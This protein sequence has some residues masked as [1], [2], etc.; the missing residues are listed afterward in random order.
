MASAYT[1]V[2]KFQMDGVKIDL[3]FA[4]VGN[5]QWLRDHSL[6]KSGRGGVND[7]AGDSTATINKGYDGEELQEI[8]DMELDDTV[9]VGLDETSVRSV[10]G[11][12][13]AQ[14]LMSTAGTSA[15]RLENFRLTLRAVKEWA[16]RIA[17]SFALVQTLLQLNIKNVFRFLLLL[18]QR[19]HGLYSNVLGFLGGVNWAILVCWVFKV[20]VSF[21]TKLADVQ[22][23]FA[24]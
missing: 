10:N 24:H 4:R 12:R 14:F 5:S 18:S 3:I 20:G 11:V 22:S 9:L 17:I 15:E 23:I 7:V 1:P 19:V 13:V 8:M 16:V 2:I 6:K 21:C